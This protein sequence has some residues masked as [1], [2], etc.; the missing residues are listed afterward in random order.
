[1]L[2]SKQ[3]SYLS[4]L[5]SSLN[6]TVM[7]GKEGNSPGVAAALAEDFK[8]RELVKLRFVAFKED[9]MDTARNLAE[10]SGAELVRVIGNVA[11]FYRRADDPE[12]RRIQL[13]V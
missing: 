2:S 13:P 6:P 1:M 10:K 3:R 5:A 11:V 9:R 4:K 7:V 8:H 12:E